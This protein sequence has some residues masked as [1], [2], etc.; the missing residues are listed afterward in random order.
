MWEREKSAEPKLRSCTTSNRSSG[1]SS[2]FG[3]RGLTEQNLSV[4]KQGGFEDWQRHEEARA[5]AGLLVEESDDLEA[6]SGNVRLADRA[7]VPVVF[8]LAKLVQQ[9]TP[10]DNAAEQRKAVLGAAQQLAQLR[11]GNHEAER[12]RLETERWEAK[13]QELRATKCK[14][15][16]QAAR[17]VEFRRRYF[18]G[19]DENFMPLPAGAIP[20]ELQTCLTANALL[21]QAAI[22]RGDLT[23]SK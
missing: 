19:L 22:D 23:E 5:W 3:G 16:E 17:A 11:R 15:A 4:W 10:S 1:G 9:A 14:E 18:P 12:V 2:Q 13:Q 20:E 6:E 7:S 8:A 21:R